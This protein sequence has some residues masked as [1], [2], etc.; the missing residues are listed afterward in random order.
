MIDIK[1]KLYNYTQAY[2]NLSFSSRLE[3]ER[4]FHVADEIDNI[5]SQSYGTI[6]DTIKNH[7]AIEAEQGYYGVWYAL[8]QSQDILLQ[9]PLINHDYVMNL[10]NA[11]VAGKRLSKRLYEYRDELAQNVTNNIINGIFEGKSYAEIAKRVSNETEASYKNALRIAITEG[12]RTS[13]ITQQ[14]SSEEAAS[15]GIDMEKRWLST[16]DGKTRDDHRK[17]DGQQVPI[18]GEF[19]IHGH[20]AK[21]PRM[22]GV[23]KEDIRCRCTS[24]NIVNGVAPELRKDNDTG[25]MGLYSNY[26]EWLEGKKNVVEEVNPA[27]RMNWLEKEM[28]KLEDEDW[29]NLT[30]DEAEE[31]FEKYD[32]EYRNLKE[33]YGSMAYNKGEFKAS[34]PN[35]ITPF[36]KD[37][38]SYQ[39]WINSLSEEESNLIWDYSANTYQTFNKIMREGP[40]AFLNNTLYRGSPDAW[41][42]K[43][44][45]DA[46]DL[47]QVI[48]N[49]EADADF[50]TYRRIGGLYNDLSDFEIGKITDFDDG[51]MSTSL[52]LKETEE[53][54]DGANEVLFTIHVKKG[55]KIG[56]YIGE[57]SQYEKEKEFLIAPKTKFKILKVSFEKTDFGKR[58][59]IELEAVE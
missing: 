2:P 9:M 27:D 33:K 55:Q 19:E 15:I 57:I 37:Q 31:L 29:G 25:E 30:E 22:F 28:S 23:A 56:A 39:N 34:S 54:G 38:E 20:K 32:E 6:E 1:K 52:S 53:F 12:G 11:P 3:V 51:Y 45:S 35:E 13:S 49:Y 42:Q 24:I 50:V 16:L 58:Q 41:K 7:S 40:E 21:Q 14:K 10:V 5:L 48:K 8:E 47:A 46:N 36:F 18:D 17:L 44:I 26:N 59:L 43:M 4:L